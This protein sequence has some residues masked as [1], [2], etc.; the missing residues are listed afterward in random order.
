[1]PHS[2]LGGGCMTPPM[3]PWPSVRIS[4]NSLRSGLSAIARRRSGLSK[5][6]SFRLTIRLRA[7]FAVTTWQM[8]C[9]ASFLTSPSCGYPEIDIILTGDE[10]QEPRRYVLDDRVFDAVEVGPVLFPIIRV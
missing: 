7:T 8:A 9:G 2:P 6:G 10:R 3:S 5:G 1:M 4:M